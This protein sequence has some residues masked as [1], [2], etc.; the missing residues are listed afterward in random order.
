MPKYKVGNVLILR[1][2]I[3]K[4]DPDDDELT[5]S[6][7]GLGWIHKS[8]IIGV[9][10]ADEPEPA[11]PALNFQVGD[12]IYHRTNREFGKVIAFFDNPEWPYLIS[13]NDGRTEQAR[14]ID[15]AS[16]KIEE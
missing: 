4:V 5:Y 16:V 8:L 3:D 10:V 6:C 15:L 11:R 2:E 13:Q 14:E 9:A 12:N 7:E 1:A